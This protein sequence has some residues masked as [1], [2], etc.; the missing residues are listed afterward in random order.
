[1]KLENIILGDQVQVDPSSS[2]NNVV[3]GNHVRVAKRCSLFGAPEHLL[4]IGDYSYIGMNAI[5]EGFNEKVTIGKYVSLAPNVYI[6]AGSGPNASVALQK[7][8]PIIKEPVTIGDHSWIGA[9]VVIM[10]GVHL[11]KY[12]V[13]GVNSFVNKSF[14]DFSII[15]GSPARMIRELTQAEREL[16]QLA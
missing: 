7:I 12:C 1:M 9:G 11:G 5:I 6:M 15:A 13:V 4:E 14:P 16:I 3:I 8:F 10:P 2:I